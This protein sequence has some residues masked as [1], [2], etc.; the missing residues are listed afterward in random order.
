MT[1]PDPTLVMP[2]QAL[3]GVRIW[4]SASLPEYSGRNELERIA[5][6]DFVS[7][8]SAGLFARSARLIHGCHPS[9]TPALLEQSRLHSTEEAPLLTLFV[10]RYWS[11]HFSPVQ[12]DALR[13]GA[14]VVEVPEASGGRAES[15]ALLREQMA[16]HCDVLVAIGG[17]K[18]DQ[19]GDAPGVP[20]ELHLALRQK[21]PS[22]LLGGI[23]G[24]AGHQTKK[25][26]E[27]L[28]H[29]RNGL[30]LYSNTALSHE[31]DPHRLSASVLAQLERLFF[32]PPSP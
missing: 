26:P 6:F 5:L 1:A 18:R 24:A 19:N 3:S 30:D 9:L 31:S 10:S 23:G 17:Q 27:L 11:K 4:L 13:R 16:S 15:L 22:F 14:A 20:A 7:E 21:L 28:E 29:L 32:R 12:S 25:C 2:A 8:F